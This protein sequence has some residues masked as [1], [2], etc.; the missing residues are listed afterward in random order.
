MN[1]YLKSVV[2]ARRQRERLLSEG[3]PGWVYS[4]SKGAF[5]H[6]GQSVG[7]DKPPKNLGKTCRDK[8]RG[9][10]K[11]LPCV[12][13]LLEAFSRPFVL[14]WESPTSALFTTDDGHSYK[15]E[16]GDNSPAALAYKRSY[17]SN[18]DVY[19]VAFA[20]VDPGL[21]VAKKYHDDV[22]NLGSPKTAMRVFSTVID[23]IN[24]FV[25]KNSPDVLIIRAKESNRASLYRRM[26]SKLSKGRF[27]VTEKSDGAG[28]VF[29]LDYE[30]HES[31]AT[32]SSGWVSPGGPSGPIGIPSDSEDEMQPQARD[33]HLMLRRPAT[34]TSGPQTT[35]K[36]GDDEGDKATPSRKNPKMGQSLPVRGF[37]GKAV[38]ENSLADEVI[39]YLDSLNEKS[40]CKSCE[41]G[42]E[43]EVGEATTGAMVGGSYPGGPINS[44]AT[45]SRDIGALTTQ[46]N[47]NYGK[48]FFKRHAKDIEARAK[49]RSKCKLGDGKCLFKCDESR[50]DLSPGLV[51]LFRKPL[52]RS[53]PPTGKLVQCAACGKKHYKQHRRDDCLTCE[54]KSERKRKTEYLSRV[55]NKYPNCTPL[56]PP[57]PDCRKASLV[58]TA[59]YNL[60]RGGK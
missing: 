38:A 51:K 9:N 16:F 23:A 56:E 12:E 48:T 11:V 3:T 21:F 25:K 58:K 26:L 52:V 32:A 1:A 55:K 40:C 14:K 54:D 35:P 31:V 47:P 42:D 20:W 4:T 49:C 41:D 29:F 46:G 34:N 57:D 36:A 5:G 39:S 43:C 18:A 15:V 13:S 2:A 6:G 27:K 19:E 53:L 60:G 30:M 24:T 45:T 22:R 33:S 17:D 10:S 28:N 59:A 8:V 44:P 50:D 37:A 7:N